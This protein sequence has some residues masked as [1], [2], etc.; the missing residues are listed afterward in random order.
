MAQYQLHRTFP[1]SQPALTR[2]SLPLDYDYLETDKAQHLSGLLG[3][4]PP[5]FSA[6][7]L[8]AI[9]VV[10]RVYL[11]L[12]DVHFNQ[13]DPSATKQFIQLFH[14]EFGQSKTLD[15]LSNLFETYPSFNP[16]LQSE[17]LQSIKSFPATNNDL[18]IAILESTL[19][20]A[21]ENENPAL[22]R[23]DG[24]FFVS[25]FTES[26]FY[27]SIWKILEDFFSTQP[28]YPPQGVSFLEL[29]REP[30]RAHPFSIYDQLI[31]I[32]DN[33]GYMLGEE[34][35]RTLLQTLD[36]LKEE[37]KSHPPG[38]KITQDPLGYSINHNLLSSDQI[39]YSADLDWMP[40]LVLIAKNVFVW[41]DQLSKQYQRPIHCLDHIPDEELAKLSRW[42]FTGLWLIGIWQRSP[43]SQKIKQLCGN[44][45]AI[46]S[47]Y[48]LYDYIIA[49][50]LGGESAYADLSRRALQYGVRLAADMVPNHMGL[51]SKWVIE[52]PNRFL[53]LPDKPYPNYT[54]TGPDLSDD[55]RLSLFIED[56]YY[57]KTDAAVVFKRVEN[58]SGQTSYI[59]HGN[60]GTSMPWND[61]AQLDFLQ[62]EVR[63]SVIQTIIHVARKFP[64][65]RFDAAMTLAKK[66]F[67]RLWFPEAGTGGAI[68]TRS[69]FGLSKS[70]FDQKMPV[71]FWREVV[72]RI[73]QDVP[74]TLLLAEAFWM[75]EGYFV[76]T[77]GMHRVYNSAFMH[78]LRDEDNSKFRD[79]IKQTLGFDPEILKRYVNFMNNPD[80]DTAISQFGSDG[81]YFAVCTLLSTLPGLPMF[82][83]GQ[84]EGYEE[85]YG[86]E[87]KRSYYDEIPDIG[88]IKRHEK[89]IFPLLL[90]RHLFAG[91]A[92]FHLYDFFTSSGTIDENVIAFSNRVDTDAALVVVHNKWGS[93]KGRIK[94]SASIDGKALHLL[95]N[96]CLDGKKD[97]LIYRDHISSLEYIRSI[98]DIKTHGIDFDLG[99]YHYHVLLDFFVVDDPD[100]IYSQLTEK[101][102]GRGTPNIHHIYLEI[103]LT[104]LLNSVVELVSTFS[105]SGKASGPTKH[106]SSDPHDT[107]FH[108][109]KIWTTFQDVYQLSDLNIKTYLDTA[110]NWL[111]CF[112]KFQ[113]LFSF[114]D[115]FVYF[116]GYP[117]LV[118]GLIKE[119]SSRL[120]HDD[121]C[122][123]NRILS[124]SLV[125]SQTKQNFDEETFYQLFDLFSKSSQDLSRLPLEPSFFADHWFSNQFFRSFIHAHEYDN[126]K[127][128]NQERMEMLF[129][130]TICLIIIDKLGNRSISIEDA[131]KLQM[132][133]D[134][135]STAFYSALDESEFK[136]DK[137]KQAFIF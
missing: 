56:H 10:G 100:D 74:D 19:L 57:D 12:I 31:Y 55:P 25:S 4:T 91:S 106:K 53:S 93:T 81:K 72:D 113:S 77:L 33:W 98:E 32:H 108:L 136:E 107:Q 126:V 64:I 111:S 50:E 110:G 86:M 103:K 83:H 87:Y 109:T 123:F 29:L 85:K 120:S 41:L 1:L 2:L 39:A 94:L 52:N 101:L 26:S 5:S 65:I 96:L 135:I 79:L 62:H 76:R 116:I 8:I 14:K 30:V 119:F 28:T 121:W 45:D 131:S 22:R 78:M 15:A 114:S 102:A 97:F 75:M 124:V 38:G 66:H 104:P 47:A 36:Q 23:A 61:T 105:C 133:I 46:P 24:L 82:G 40:G 118:W 3:K 128:F 35:L 90:K 69:G 60:D 132:K 20:T 134:K 115:Q 99:A 84:I 54:F 16:G 67:Q 89:E 58:H 9:G 17:T 42:G 68:P 44:L 48:S 59:Y 43:A 125:L 112:G 18:L 129:Q 122:Q 70:D 73:A 34:F 27:A 6:S 51:Y 7:E 127:W 37:I 88:L 117:I 11:K 130:A 63:E 13:I 49:D 137:F 80:E 21:L 92:N 95:E 71:E